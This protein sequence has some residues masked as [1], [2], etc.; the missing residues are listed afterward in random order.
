M[1]KPLFIAL[2]LAFATGTSAAP[3]VISL[4]PHITELAFAAG[5]TPVGVS[6]WSDYP[7]QA[8]NIEHV[9]NWQGIKIERIIAL[10]PDVVIAWRGGN[11]QRQVDQLQSLG[12]NIVWMDPVTIESTISSLRELQAWSPHPEQARQH[13]DEM[14]RE[15]AALRNRYQT[16]QRKRVFLQFGQQPLFTAAQATLQNQVLQL[17][18]GENI[19]AD[20]HV[21]WPQISREQ[22]LMRHPDVIV[23]TGEISRVPAIQQF[24][25][26][27]LNVPIIAIN[28]DWFSRPGP[29]ILLAAK[30]LCQALQPDK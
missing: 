27:Q 23:I 13:A 3:R 2:L 4:S 21:P 7:A 17:C 28:D 19:F 22:V 5:I 30:Q 15:L 26:P 16:P 20:G 12:I 6:A 9:A 25:Q 10:K 24:W 29:R 8:R 14:T 11:P 18:G 1:L